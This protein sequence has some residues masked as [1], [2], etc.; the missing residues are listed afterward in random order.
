[1][2]AGMGA[3]ETTEDP[4]EAF[5]RA[6]V[7]LS[8]AWMVWVL[9]GNLGTDSVKPIGWALT[10]VLLHCLLKVSRATS[11]TAA[12]WFSRCALTAAFAATGLYLG[13]HFTTVDDMRRL[14][15]A[16]VVAGAT[17]VLVGLWFFS[18][19]MQDWLDAHDNR[20]ELTRLWRQAEKVTAVGIGLVVAVS[21]YAGL[22]DAEDGAL[23]LSTDAGTFVQSGLWA[24]LLAAIILTTRAATITNR[25]LE[26]YLDEL[27]RPHRR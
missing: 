23:R 14:G 4:V 7:T 6:V 26:D 2:S 1:M 9:A 15:E 3:K 5:A 22:L 11:N 8:G 25:S 19:G 21:G 10:P 18:R 13:G 16:M 24:A 12:L 20:H 27:D 17:S